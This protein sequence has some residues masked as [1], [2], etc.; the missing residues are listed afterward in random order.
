MVA[1]IRA[2]DIRVFP[3][4]YLQISLFH[5][6]LV[7]TLLYIKQRKKNNSKKFTMTIFFNKAE[8]LDEMGL[9]L[10]DRQSENDAS[11]H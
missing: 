11:R 8:K 6:P 1:A 5:L 4:R 10:L 7:L 9:F 2:I 3:Y